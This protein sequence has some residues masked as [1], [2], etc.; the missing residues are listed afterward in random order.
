M[1]LV[2]KHCIESYWN[3]TSYS[4]DTPM[5]RKVFTMRTFKLLLRF[6][7]ASDSDREPKRG[8]DMYDPTY[9]FKEVLE[10]FNRTWFCEYQLHR[11]I[12]IDESIVE[13]K[14]RH[15][16]VNYI[17]IKKHHQWGPKEYNIADV[18][19]Y[20]HHTI[21]H[22]K[23]MKLSEFGQLFDV[24]DTLLKPTSYTRIINYLL[25]TIIQVFLYVTRCW[26]RTYM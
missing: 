23:G 15:V 5:F 2:K 21:F 25:I 6:F 16:L 12:S 11:G 18:S 14:C 9:K 8:T 24:C 13:F 19:G 3:V 1:E 4:Q 26:I 20:M 10:F 7:H 22:M 17:Q